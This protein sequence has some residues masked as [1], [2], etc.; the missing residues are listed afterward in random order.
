[1]TAQRVE[2]ALTLLGFGLRRE[3][4]NFIEVFAGKSRKIVE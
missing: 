2:R 1:V 3:V 4:A